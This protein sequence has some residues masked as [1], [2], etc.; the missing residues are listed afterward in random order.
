MTGKADVLV[1]GGGVIGLSCALSLLEAGRSVIVLE[2]GTAGCAASHGNCGTLT[3]SHAAPLALPGTLAL[4]LRWLLKPDA[5]LRIAPRADAALLRWLASFALRCNWR[6]ALHATA[7]KAPLLARSRELVGELVRREC[8]ECEFES[9]GTL[10]VY[11]DAAAFDQACA[12][13]ERFAAVAPPVEVLGAQATLAREPALKPGVAGSLFNPGDASL[14]PDRYVAGL[15]RLVRAR[16]G[17]IEEG[18]RV[19]GFERDA[20][21]IAGVATT[22]GRRQGRDIVLALGARSP[23]LARSLGV[24]LPIQPGKGYSITFSRPAICPR[25]PLTLKDPSVCVTAWASGYRLGST[26]EFAGYDERLNRTRLDALRRGAAAFL[27]E[28]EGATVN[29]EWY[30]WRPMTPDDLPLIGRAAAIPNLVIASG[31]GMLGMT[32]SAGT[33]LLVSE[34]VCGKPPQIDITPFDPARFH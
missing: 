31:H 15:A 27:H 1:L 4:A 2:Q 34:I 28:P 7:A 21:G 20:N 32:M 8:I 24:H 33:G 9:S 25:I 14:R 23:R 18:A 12:L 19:D 11:R 22:R 29:E 26:M 10:N 17:V 16:G 6:D 3:P 13:H 5:P 30:G